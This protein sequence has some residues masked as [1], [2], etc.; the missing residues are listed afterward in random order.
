MYRYAAT[1][2]LTGA[3]YGLFASLLVGLF[4]PL[5][6]GEYVTEYAGGEHMTKRDFYKCMLDP[7]LEWQTVYV[8]MF[9]GLKCD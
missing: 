2:S 1:S 5:V 7:D 9:K 8:I 3:G 4:S 6:G